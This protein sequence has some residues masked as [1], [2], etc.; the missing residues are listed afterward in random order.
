MAAMNVYFPCPVA[1][2]Q[3]KSCLEICDLWFGWFCCG[4]CL[5]QDYVEHFDMNLL[6]QNLNTSSGQTSGRWETT[7]SLISTVK[8]NVHLS[9]VPELQYVQECEVVSV[10]PTL[11][12][13][14][15]RL[16]SLPLSFV[17]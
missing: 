3:G 10:A 14:N 12:M 9:S 5:E 15:S 6:P 8:T 16:N 1:I 2:R 11:P 7:S 13:R 17:M 4:C